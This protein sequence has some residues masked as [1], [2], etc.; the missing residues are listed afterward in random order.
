MA[1][2]KHWTAE[3]RVEF[4]SKFPPATKQGMWAAEQGLPLECNPYKKRKEEDNADWIM[5]W[6]SIPKPIPEKRGKLIF[7]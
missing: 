4:F 7:N 6:A 3:E 5:G 1:K 2:I